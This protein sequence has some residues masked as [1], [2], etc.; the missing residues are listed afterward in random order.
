M[1]SI[2]SKYTTNENIW[3]NFKWG[4]L[5]NLNFCKI[6]YLGKPTANEIII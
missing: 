1:S 3:G 5:A 2:G 6:K 4:L